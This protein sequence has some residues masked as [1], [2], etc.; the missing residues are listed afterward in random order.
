MQSD[1]DVARCARINSVV[2]LTNPPVLQ[3]GSSGREKAAG[4]LFRR[5]LPRFLFFFFS[6]KTAAWPLGSLG[7]GGTLEQLFLNMVEIVAVVGAG[8][9]EG[10]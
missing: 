3:V 4:F 8:M 6:P 10:H 9:G 5:N 7:L 1:P 2:P